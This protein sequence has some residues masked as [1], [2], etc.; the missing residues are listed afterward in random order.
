[1][2]GVT[3][4]TEARIASAMRFLWQ[5]LGLRVEGSGAAA[6][7]PVLHGAK[8][9]RTEGDLVVVLTGRNVDEEVFRRVVDSAGPC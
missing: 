9:L 5:N 6:L 2:A 3:V 7:V 8:P 1:M 4:V